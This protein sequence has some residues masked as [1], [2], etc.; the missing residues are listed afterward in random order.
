MASN[1]LVSAAVRT[2]LI[3]SAVT[4]A[5]FPAYVAAQA[6][7]L[8]EIVVTGSLIPQDLNAPGIP[9]TLMSAD[10][11]RDTGVSTNML[12]VLQR[13]QPFFYGSAN[14]G[15]DNGNIQ[16]GSTNGGSQ[17]SLRNRATLVLLNGRRV[18]VSP[19]AASGGNNFVDVNMIP[20]TAIERIEILPDGAS[21]TYGADAV[22]GV[23]NLILKTDY[24]GIEVGGRYGTDERGQYTERSYYAT[25]GTS[26]ENTRVTFSTE[27]AKN[28]PIFQ[29]DRSWARGQFRS[30]SFAGSVNY[31]DA[32]GNALF[33]YLNPDLNAP[34]KNLD[35]TPAQLVASGIYQGP[36][37]QGQVAQFFDL[38]TYPTMILASERKSGLVAAEH[39]VNEHLELFGDFLISET[40]T[41]S[42]LNAQPVS[43]TVAANNANNPFNIAVTARNRFLEFPRRYM[44][45]TTLWRGVAGI[46][47]DI[48]G[49]WKYELAANWNNAKSQF[50]NPGLIDGAAYSRA[51][52]NGTYNPFARQQAPGVLESFVGIQF[53]DYE[54][55][56]TSYDAK[57]FGDLF[58]LP[59]GKVQLAVGADTR[60]ETLD[61]K[62]DKLDQTGGWLQA[63]PTQPFQAELSSQGYFAEVRVPV[64]SPDFNVPGFYALELSLAGRQEVY[65]TTDDPFVPKFTMRW[66]PFGETFAIRGGYSESFTA[67]TLF[68][69]FGPVNSGFTPSRNIRRYDT[70]GNPILLNGQQV[71]ATNRQYRSRSGSNE[72]LDPS[73]SKNWTVGLEW[74]P[75]GAMEGFELSLDWFNMEEEDLIDSVD[76]AIILQS[77]E[78]L[79]PSSPYASLVRLG[80]PISTEV[81]FDDGDPITTPGQITNRASDSVWLSNSLI[82]I[83]GVDQSGLDFKVG[84]TYETDTLGTFSGRLSGVWLAEYD[85]AGAPGLAIEERAGTFGGAVPG[86]YADWRAV[87]Q[88]GWTS[89]GW[90]AGVNANFIPEIDDFGNGYSEEMLGTVDSY[91]AW[92]IRVGFDFADMPGYA[93]GLRLNAGINNV[94]DEDPP[95]IAGEGNQ[96]HDIS[97]YDPVGRFYYAELA[98]KF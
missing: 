46:R 75:E 10:D 20:V 70:S 50:R 34:P 5:A 62:N 7:E 98:Y 81:Y 83:A 31:I 18:A 49:S 25:M 28:D 33:F 76:S 72:F 26:S 48:T 19:V 96:S 92:D 8:E 54:S 44:T 97:T 65:D 38:S 78:E 9:V 63:T 32:G 13:S 73:E 52:A 16:S 90:S 35:L 58:S 41:E 80:T 84:Y 55:T 24:E 39:T 86:V 2:A 77:V 61:Y 22:G 45:D 64:F 4:A 93:S 91:M 14:L 6:T 67:P 82:N 95:F 94:L 87:L 51:V 21:A 89:G 29:K 59:A 66:Q 85:Y 60:D 11:I 23:V 53:R 36:L 43:G 30:P 88:L 27:F 68:E 74:R 1:K 3:T 69:L 40:E 47:G 37:T 56:L 71:V 42:Q 57:V 79:G 12:D 15:N 17:I